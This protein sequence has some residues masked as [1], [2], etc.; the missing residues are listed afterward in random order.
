M[1]PQD[2]LSMQQILQPYIALNLLEKNSDGQLVVST[3]NGQ[4]LNK[5]VKTEEQMKQQE[6]IVLKNEKVIKMAMESIKEVVT[7]PNPSNGGPAGL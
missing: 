7:K 6:L 2:S 4:N 5:T 1:K 3:K